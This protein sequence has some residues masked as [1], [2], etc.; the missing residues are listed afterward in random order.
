MCVCALVVRIIK[1]ILRGCIVRRVKP[2]LFRELRSTKTVLFCFVMIIS[3]RR[4][5]VVNTHF[6]R[7]PVLKQLFVGH[8]LLRLL[9]TK[10]ISASTSYEL[11]GHTVYLVSISHFDP[12]CFFVC[13]FVFCFFCLKC[14][15]VQRL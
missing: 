14:D 2:V 10:A 15:F 6:N 5:F 1:S 9:H 11:I 13:L 4:D 3:P 8:A 7:W 12:K